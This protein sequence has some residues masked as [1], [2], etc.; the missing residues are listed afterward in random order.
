MPDAFY[1]QYFFYQ[2]FF[3]ENLKVKKQPLPK[4]EAA[5]LHLSI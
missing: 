5:A 2:C 4:F 3:G 1:Q